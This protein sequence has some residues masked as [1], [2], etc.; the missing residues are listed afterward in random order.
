[1]Q[2]WTTH[3]DPD[4][5]PDPDKFMPERWFKA[6]ESMNELYM[7]FSK[8]TRACL[9]INLANMELKITCAALVA[10]YRVGLA[11]DMKSED[12]EMRVHFLVY[13]VGRKCNLTFERI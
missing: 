10:R 13:P 7:P 2:A 8:G 5:F 11:G 9:G 6:T 12:M 1:M 4:A 3:R